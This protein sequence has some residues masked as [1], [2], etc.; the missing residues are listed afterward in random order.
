LELQY[1]KYGGQ[2]C[3]PACLNT[4]ANVRLKIC[5]RCNCVQY[6]SRS[7]QKRDWTHAQAGHRL[8]CQRLNDIQIVVGSQVEEAT[9]YPGDEAK[10]SQILKCL[11]PWALLKLRQLHSGVE[12][13]GFENEIKSSTGAL[14]HNVWEV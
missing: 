2:C 14:H 13:M 8:W 1:L 7:C 3:A 6:C 4:V 11:E 12:I 10:A 5:L 9:L